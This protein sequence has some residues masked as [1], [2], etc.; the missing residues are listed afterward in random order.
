MKEVPEFIKWRDKKVLIPSEKI[1]AA[2]VNEIP[3]GTTISQAELRARL[4]LGHCAD[5]TCP[6]TTARL[7]KQLGNAIPLE[8]LILSKTLSEALRKQGVLDG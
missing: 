5:M 6:V 8:R 7:I 4:A 1:I 2:A 3:K